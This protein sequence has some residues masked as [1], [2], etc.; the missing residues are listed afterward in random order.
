MEI[1]DR[2]G[3]AVAGTIADLDLADLRQVVELNVFGP[4]VAMQAAIPVMRKQGGGL[5]IN[6]SSMVT[7]MHIPGLGGYA[8][9]KS[10]LNMLSDTARVELASDNIRIVSIF[11]RMTATD[12]GKNSLGNRVV[13]HE[14]RQ[15]PSPVDTAEFVAEKILAAAVSEPEE[16]YMQ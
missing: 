13:R 8:A 16:Q 10:A 4:L 5:I 12:F 11:H 2:A 7:K 1:R 15:A 9:T 14:Q 3:Q 6:V